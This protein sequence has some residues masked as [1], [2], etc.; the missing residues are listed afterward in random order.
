M[1]NLIKQFN[2]SLL[3]F[4]QA[5]N[6]GLVSAVQQRF[7]STDKPTTGK[8]DSPIEKQAVDPNADPKETCNFNKK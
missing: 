6:L 8:L 7:A 4:R 3:A 1:A 5:N 2:R